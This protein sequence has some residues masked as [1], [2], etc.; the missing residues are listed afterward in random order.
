MIA[1]VTRPAFLREQLDGVRETLAAGT[2]DATAGAP[3]SAVADDVSADPASALLAAMPRGGTGPPSSGGDPTGADDAPFLARDPVVS[4]LQTSLEECLRD[5][6]ADEIDDET[7][8]DDDVGALGAVA[9]LVRWLRHPERFS[10][11]DPRWI[12]GIAEAVLRRLEKGNHPFNQTPAQ[13]QIADDARV[14][15]VGDWG[16]GL[17]RARAVATYMREEVADARAEGREA[18]VVHLGDVYYSGDVVEYDRRMLAD[19][20]WPVSAED[21][22]AGV[23]SWSLNGNHDMYSGGW[24][25][26]DH[27][28]AQERFAAQRS[29]DGRGTSFF[30]ITSPS[31][32][33]V[34]LD[35]SWDK[36][37]L[38]L[39]DTGE[40]HDPQAAFVGQVAADSERR[41]MLLSH[42]QLM[43]VY[44]AGDVGRTLSAK[45]ADLLAADRITAWYWGHEPA[46]WATRP[47]AE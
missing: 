16:T 40:L 42:H 3:A 20:L 10:K 13:A 14:V 45:L 31:W 22:A 39:G 27:L 18:H 37:P 6:H 33:L 38:S 30:R 28:L 46:A 34:G 11:D 4:L 1:D 12:T 19:G 32:D 43:S 17:P 47:P 7:P 8:A 24:A 21:A 29:P 5:E 36:D 35:T 2:L 9:H 44:D 25:Y 26:F 23:T 15:L 41:L